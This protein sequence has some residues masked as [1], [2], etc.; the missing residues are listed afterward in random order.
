MFTL[1][2][3]TYSYL[4]YHSVAR[5]VFLTIYVFLLSGCAIDNFGLVKVQHFEN[6]T[7]HMISKESWG[8]YLSTNN[9]DAG[10][11]FGHMK[12]I[13]LYPKNLS[14]SELRLDNLLTTVQQDQF[15]ETENDNLDAFITRSPIAWITNNQGLIFNTNQFRLGITLGLESHDAIRLPRDFEGVFVFKY[16]LNGKVQAYFYRQ[17]PPD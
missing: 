10:L 6:E 7:V 14:P 16:S 9:A 1:S 5:L 17:L 15:I 8:A 4:H 3:K 13:L 11:M 2:V 12:R